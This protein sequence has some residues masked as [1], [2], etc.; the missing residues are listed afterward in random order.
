MKKATNSKETRRE[1]NG[2]ED[3]E[4]G[5][6]LRGI[7]YHHCD[8]MNGVSSV[9]FVSCPCISQ[10]RDNLWGRAIR[11]KNTS[12]FFKD[13]LNFFLLVPVCGR[14]GGRGEGYGQPRQFKIYW[15]SGGGGGGIPQKYAD[16]QKNKNL[17]SVEGV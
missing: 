1:K 8:R 9:S 15:C 6:I 16:K 5:E 11:A 7:R 13:S 2:E 10:V 12:G 4:L 17:E 3:F 14:G